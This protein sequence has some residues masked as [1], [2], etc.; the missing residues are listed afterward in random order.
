MNNNSLKLS[1]IASKAPNRRALYNIISKEYD[2]A[3]FGP[4]ITV[5]YL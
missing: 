5:P 3:N 1:D 4:C 2:I